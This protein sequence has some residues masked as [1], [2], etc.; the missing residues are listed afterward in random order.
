[1]FWTHYF[2]WG[3]AIR[4]AI[5]E[6]IAVRKKSGI[7]HSSVVNI[8]AAVDQDTY[9]AFVLGMVAVTLGPGAWDPGAGW[10][11]AVSGNDFAVW[12]VG[13]V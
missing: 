5:R 1:M 9:A 2:D 10:R 12:T 13:G 8:G 4:G 3:A 11:V 7:T 6:L